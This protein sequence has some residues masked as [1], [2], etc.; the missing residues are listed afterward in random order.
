MLVR[1]NP[2]F[3]NIPSASANAPGAPWSIVN[4]IKDFHL[5]SS[6]LYPPVP[7]LSSLLRIKNLVTLS[8][9]SSIP[10]CSTSK[11]YT[12]AASLLAIAALLPPPPT[13][14]AS[15]SCATVSAAL[16]VLDT[17]CLSTPLK[18]PSRNAV[19]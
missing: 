11:P 7:S 17:S 1:L 14:T 8:P 9:W 2:C 4:D 5:L 12:S 3:L 19:H 6:T 13:F 18:C 15:C 10:S 16:D